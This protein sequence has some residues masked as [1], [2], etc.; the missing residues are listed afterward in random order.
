[1]LDK[2]LSPPRWEPTPVQRLHP[3][4]VRHPS[5][6]TFLPG[7]GP[8]P[9]TELHPSF[10]TCVSHFGKYEVGILLVSALFPAY[11]GYRANRRVRDAHTIFGA[12]AGAAAGLF[13]AYY[14]AYSKGCV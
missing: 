4:A 8:Y 10:T 2:L 9:I 11:L 3:R 14:Y 1:M 13:Y 12:V 6:Q 7:F 5:G